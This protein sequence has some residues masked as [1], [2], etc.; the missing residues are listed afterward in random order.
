MAAGA[1]YERPAAILDASCAGLTP[2]VGLPDL[3]RLID[4]QNSGKP[5][6]CAHASRKK[7]F[8]R[9]GWIAGHKRV[10]ARLP[11]RYARQ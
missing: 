2:Q 11:T 3:R 1:A 5:E 6:F 4:M 7:R 8:D 9:K 10:H